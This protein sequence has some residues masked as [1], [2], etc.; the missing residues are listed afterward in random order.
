MSANNQSYSGRSRTTI[1][2]TDLQIT[3]EAV[4]WT[5]NFPNANL[6]S[7]ECP[8]EALPEPDTMVTTMVMVTH[9]LR[10]RT[11]MLDPHRWPSN[12]ATVCQDV[13]TDPRPC[14]GDNNSTLKKI[15]KILK[16]P[17]HNM[18]LNKIYKIER[19]HT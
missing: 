10:M 18:F 4:G 1:T 11:P 6:W 13:V 8:P 19:S 7:T 17:I 16:L 3:T 5:K 9:Y 12:S 15:S 14:T 2:A